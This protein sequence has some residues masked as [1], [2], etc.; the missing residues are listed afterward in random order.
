[1]REVQKFIFIEEILKKN[2]QIAKTFN[3]LKPKYTFENIYAVKNIEEACLN[4]DILIG[5]TNGKAVIN[6]R[7]INKLKNT[8]I[9]IDAGKGTLQ[10]NA[11]K[12]AFQKNIKIFRTDVT[13][14]LNGLIEKSFK[15]E[16]TNA[17]KF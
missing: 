14:S 11:L 3:F 12:L 8:A 2:Y 16:K 6:S 7:I 4:A 10:Q 9:I 5:T 13:A 17:K 1:M 15:M